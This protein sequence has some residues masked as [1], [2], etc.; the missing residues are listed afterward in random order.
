[1][2][3]TASGT[4]FSFSMKSWLAFSDN[5]LH[6]NNKIELIEKSLCSHEKKKKSLYKSKLS[7]NELSIKWID[8]FERCTNNL[9]FC[10]TIFPVQGINGLRDS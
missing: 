7:C 8:F 10:A 6:F 9:W 1:M 5:S 4:V 3:N 2:V